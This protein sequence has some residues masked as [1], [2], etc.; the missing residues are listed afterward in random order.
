MESVKMDGE[1]IVVDN[2]STDNTAAIAR[3][4]GAEVVFE[5]FNQISRARNAGARYSR[6]N[7]LIFLDADTLLSKEL[8]QI[9]LKRLS[10]RK[11]CG[12]GAL[13]GLYDNIPPMIRWGVHLWNGFSKTLGL[14]A[15]CFIYCLR[16]GFRQIGG[17]S[18]KV[19]ASEEFWFSKNLKAW[20]K[21]RGMD[22]EIIND[23]SVITSARKLQW[24]SP[25]ELIFILLIGAFPFTVRYRSLCSFW[26]RRPPR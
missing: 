15:G 19:Y 20:G 13:V 4:Y 26:Y 11:C 21:K 1:V 14:A 10:T 6:G 7:F 9:A 18:E 3:Y 12:G 16:E 8:L 25:F 22:F 5:P 17:F 2:N 23:P 24:F